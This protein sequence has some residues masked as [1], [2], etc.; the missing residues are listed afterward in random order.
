MSRNR[1]ATHALFLTNHTV[2]MA[3]MRL[4]IQYPGML[5]GGSVAWQLA[6]QIKCVTKGLQYHTVQDE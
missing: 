2:L 3:E 6:Q 1:M 4:Q 5:H